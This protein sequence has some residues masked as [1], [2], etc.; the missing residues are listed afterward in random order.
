MAF[1]VR[2]KM[3]LLTIAILAFATYRA[4]CAELKSPDGQ[5][6]IE[7]FD[8]LPHES[9]V[10]FK[11]A[12]TGKILSQAFS[13]GYDESSYLETAWSPDSRYLAVVER[14]TRTTAEVSVFAF[15]GDSV[16]EVRLPDYRL[17]LLGHRKLVDGGR[18]H[19]VSKLRWVNSTLTFYCTGQWVDG[20]GDPDIEPDN[21]YHFDIALAFGG[22][23]SSPDPRLATVTATKPP[24]PEG[25]QGGTGQPATRPE[26]KSEG[27][28]KPQPEAEGRS[29]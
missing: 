16:E 24:K 8:A 25:E 29:R 27:S 26:S 14:G 10:R 18:Y 4:A 13:N 1:D 6:E 17:N 7:Y 12:K 5:Y 11:N 20:S 9:N 19:W 28:D 15:S 23:G 2:Q 21:W 3:K 22:A